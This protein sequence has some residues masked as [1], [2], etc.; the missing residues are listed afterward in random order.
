[1]PRIEFDPLIERGYRLLVSFKH[2]HEVA[3]LV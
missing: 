2:L 1:M 3:I